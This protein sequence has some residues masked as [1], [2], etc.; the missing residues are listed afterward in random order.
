MTGEWTL[1]SHQVAVRS[2]NGFEDNH[3]FIVGARTETW[4]LRLYKHLRPEMYAM[5]RTSAMAPDTLARHLW[6]N[7]P[8]WERVDDTPCESCGA[9]QALCAF[10]TKSARHFIEGPGSRP[11]STAE[12]V[13]NLNATTY[14]CD[15]HAQ[16]FQEAEE[17]CQCKLEFELG[18][19]AEKDECQCDTWR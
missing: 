17:S 19:Y 7:E 3:E 15:D 13:A 9:Y 14:L 12:E 6:L 16:P 5:V 1:V 18:M 2:K 11:E 4:R 8:G 10:C